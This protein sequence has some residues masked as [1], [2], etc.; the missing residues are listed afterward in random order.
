MTPPAAS[1]IEMI[2]AG[3]GVAL[4]VKRD[5]L[6]DE[7]VSGNK[8]F[9]LKYNA[10]A[11]LR[12]GHKS[13]LTFGGAFSNHIAATA[14]YC[15]RHGM[16][17]TGIIRGERVEPLN[18]TLAHAESQGMHLEF[19]S[20]ESYRRKSDPAFLKSLSER[21]DDPFIIPEGG[22]NEWGV[23][24]AR[25]IMDE[26]CKAFDYVCVAMGTGT[27]FAGVLLEAGENQR[28]IGF[29]VLRHPNLLAD[30][31]AFAPG[32]AQVAPNRYRI[33]ED[34]H[35]GGYA[36]WNAALIDF[37]KKFQ[38]QS[39]IPLEPV[40]TGKL[41]FGITDLIQKGFFERGSRVLAIHTGGFD[42]G[43]MTS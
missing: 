9:K 12:L 38:E 14:S 41:L 10:E 29:P 17:C 43:R 19:V 4:Y 25:E 2:P 16:R 22:A 31:A 32:L 40:Y 11:A 15:A 20:R 26:R 23:M 42:R 33:I 8:L 36:K 34:Y 24:G 5:D 30:V 39:G 21:F 27:T 1:P 37:I 3:H 35:F 13:V 6:L 28:I 7:Y 18:T